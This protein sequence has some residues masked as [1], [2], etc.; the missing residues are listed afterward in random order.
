MEIFLKDKK[1]NNENKLYTSKNKEV[2]DSIPVNCLIKTL[3]ND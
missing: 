3:K 2:H 1:N